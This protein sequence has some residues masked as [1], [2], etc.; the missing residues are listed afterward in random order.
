[1]S[2]DGG[3]SGSDGCN[4]NIGSDGGTSEGTAST[5]AQTDEKGNSPQMRRQ[6]AAA[7]GDG[8]D[9]SKSSSCT[10]KDN[11]S[12]ATQGNNPNDG[13]EDGIVG[14]AAVC[15]GTAG[16]AGMES[17]YGGTKVGPSL[18]ASDEASKKGGDK[19]EEAEAAMA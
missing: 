14:A 2:G 19:E 10:S 1:V 11:A 6:E 16:T 7:G 4:E 17:R 18:D 9:V 13:T 15:S 8:G 5:V 12:R 3:G